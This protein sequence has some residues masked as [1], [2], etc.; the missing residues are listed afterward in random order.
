MEVD[1]PPAAMGKD[2][3]KSWP[4]EPENKAPQMKVDGKDIQVECVEKLCYTQLT[5]PINQRHQCCYQYTYSSCCINNVLNIKSEGNVKDLHQHSQS[6]TKQPLAS[7]CK[8]APSRSIVATSCS[9]C[10]C[11]STAGVM[12][13][14]SSRCTVVSFNT[15]T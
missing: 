1:G 3:D 4:H 15:I 10:Q 6:A 13:I 9:Q 12:R 11:T 14:A 7:V 5:H 2:E 8:Y